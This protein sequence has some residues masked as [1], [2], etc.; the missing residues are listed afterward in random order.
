MGTPLHRGRVFSAADREGSE[1]VAI[2]SETTARALWPNENALGKCVVIGNRTAPCARVVG[3]VSDLHHSGLKEEP[4]LQFYV[5]VGQEHGFSGSWLLVRPRGRVSTAWPELRAALE[6]AD[7]AIHALDVRLLARGLDGELRP[8]RLGMVAFGLSAMLA[9]VVAA[10]GL[11]SIMA[12]AVAWRR[13]EIGVRLA[14][15]AHPRSIARLVVGQGARLASIGVA[16]GLVI[17][18]GARRFVEPMLFNT[19]GMDPVVLVA[20]V[21]LLELLAVVAGWVPARRA[22]GVSPTESLRAE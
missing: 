5:P 12:H 3:V 16:L 6:R 8:L 18:I 19:S 9:L 4:S 13:H 15:G 10:L 22:V 2:V 14:L 17:A 1:A 20:A 21:V 7:P 11:Y